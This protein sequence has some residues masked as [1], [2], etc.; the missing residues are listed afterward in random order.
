[1]RGWTAAV[2]GAAALALTACGEPSKE[3]IMK[4]AEG[5]SSKADLR[6]ALG[7]PDDIVAVG[8]LERWTY[9]ASNG[10]VTFVITGDNVTLKAAAPKSDGDE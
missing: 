5:V 2:L 7:D 3:D 4:D 1:M 10:S 8:P 9:K 6:A